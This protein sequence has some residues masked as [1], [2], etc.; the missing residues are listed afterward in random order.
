MFA[1]APASVRLRA[2]SG[3]SLRAGF[4]F[5]SVLASRGLLENL[6]EKSAFSLASLWGCAVIVR[7]AATITDAG[8]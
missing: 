3:A 5:G 7:A 2:S 1:S 6:L 8:P 4:G